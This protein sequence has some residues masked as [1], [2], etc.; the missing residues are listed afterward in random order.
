MSLGIARN[1]ISQEYAPTGVQPQPTP[2]TA[3]SVAP[4]EFWLP[5]MPEQGDQTDNMNLQDQQL[6]APE[7]PSDPPSAE[8]NEPGHVFNKWKVIPYATLQTTFDDNIFIASQNP[9][10]DLYTTLAAGIAGGWGAVQRN[11]NQSAGYFRQADT[12][13]VEINPPEEGNF[14]YANYTM[15]ETL[16]AKDT[17]ENSFNQD[18]SVAGEWRFEKVLFGASVKYQT[19]SDVDI[20]IGG[21][22]NHDLL[23]AKATVGY[24]ISEK[25]GV[26]LEFAST[27]NYYPTALN[28]TD[29]SVNSWINYQATGK[30][31]TGLGVKLGTLDVESSPSQTYEQILLR[32]SYL[33]AGKLS[34]TA[35]VG[36]EA[37]QIQGSNH[38][39]PVFTFGAV[40]SPAEPTTIYLDAFRQT[41]S[42]AVTAGENIATTGITL[43]IRQRCYQKIY[44]TLEGGY[45]HGQYEEVIQTAL[46]NRVDDSLDFRTSLSFDYTKWI[47]MELSYEYRNS[48]STQSTS[49]FSENLFSLQLNVFF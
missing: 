20:D 23:T 37:R 19:L 12:P 49:S 33:A 15:S 34:F 17:A 38:F 39:D 30:L 24:G 48:H 43:R 5:A 41:F 1:G 29:T 32:G 18:A 14:V 16:F 4:Q 36:A 13:K 35:T 11:L 45:Q 9:Q 7:N 22:V 31:G 46:P 26:A 8:N 21:R 42:S 25:I 3:P 40:Y 28:S 10:A 47:T 44:L 27:S 6:L 2:S